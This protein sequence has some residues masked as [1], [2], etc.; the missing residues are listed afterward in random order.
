M[1]DLGL[2]KL[3]EN[4]DVR[5]AAYQVLLQ[6][7]GSL[8]RVAILEKIAEFGIVVIGKVPTDTLAA[9]MGRDARL[10]SLGKGMWDIR[11]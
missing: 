10:I 6:E 8:H 9:H 1:P 5:E 2:R 11:R 4:W 7:G 3:S